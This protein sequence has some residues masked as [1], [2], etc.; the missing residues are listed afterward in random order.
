MTDFNSKWVLWFHENKDDWSINGYKKIITIGNLEEFW[1]LFNNI[2]SISEYYFLLLKEGHK[3][4]WEAEENINGGTWSIKINKKEADNHFLKMAI[5]LVG[6]TLTDE[7]NNII[8]MS[9]SPK[10][11][12][13][14]FKIWNNNDKCHDN[15]KFNKNYKEL[16]NKEHIMYKCFKEG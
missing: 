15:V 14:V 10:Q 5:Y 16:Q 7:P 13:T 6:E 2:C 3:P 12:F 4:L 9:I 8:G 11:T 1:N